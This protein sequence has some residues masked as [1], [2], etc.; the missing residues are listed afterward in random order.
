MNLKVHLIWLFPQEID[1]LLQPGEKT[2]AAAAFVRRSWH[3]GWTDLCQYPG[4]GR[5]W[6][7]ELAIW[8]V[9]GKSFFQ[10]RRM[11]QSK[12]KRTKAW[13]YIKTIRN[14]TTEAQSPHP[15]I[16]MYKLI[17]PFLVALRAGLLVGVNAANPLAVPV[18][19]NGNSAYCCTCR[20]LLVD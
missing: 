14:S 10:T 17:V 4:L 7:N 5:R 20:V 18:C 9:V 12:P 3:V 19:V 8:R 1:I 2:S 15:I 13:L 16:M 11:S 6:W